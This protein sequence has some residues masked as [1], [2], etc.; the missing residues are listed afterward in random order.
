MGERG[1]DIAGTR[2]CPTCYSRKGTH[3]IRQGRL[4]LRL[5]TTLH[6]YRHGEVQP[7]FRLTVIEHLEPGE[8]PRNS[9]HGRSREVTVHLPIA[10][11]SRGCW[12]NE[13]QGFF[14]FAAGEGCNGR[15]SCFV[16]RGRRFDTSGVGTVDFKPV[17]TAVAPDTSGYGIAPESVTA[18]TGAASRWEDAAV[19]K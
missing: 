3:Q 11:G 1:P 18:P 8:F 17:P 14:R 4:L 15:A 16:A 6:R 7:Q 13:R 12:S 2:M 5:A 10:V 9:S 19:R